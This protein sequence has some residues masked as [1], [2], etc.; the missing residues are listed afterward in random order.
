MDVVTPDGDLKDVLDRI[1]ERLEVPVANS[2]IGQR[3]LRVHGRNEVVIIK[4]AAR[5]HWLGVSALEDADSV[6]AESFSGTP[7]EV[8]V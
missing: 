6:V 4:P 7:H 2:L 5:R 8:A 3:E 1:G